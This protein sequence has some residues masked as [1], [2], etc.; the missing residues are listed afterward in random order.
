MKLQRGDKIIRNQVP[1]NDLAEPF[2]DILRGHTLTVLA[3][4]PHSVRVYVE[5]VS[6]DR[7]SILGIGDSQSIA[8]PLLTEAHFAI[9]KP[10]SV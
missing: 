4:G 1:L 9:L 2:L 6:A 10:A 8:L 3:V 7:R 5:G